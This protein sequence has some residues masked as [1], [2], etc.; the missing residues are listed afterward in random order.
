[1]SLPRVLIGIHAKDAA[2]LLPL[3]LACIEALDYPKDRICVTIK[4]NNNT[5]DTR[6]ILFDWLRRMRKVYSR[7]ALDDADVYEKVERFDRH[8]WNPERFE[9]L[10]FIR[11]ASIE[12]T[13]QWQCDF[14]FTADCDNFVR[15]NTLRALVDLNLPI[16]APF[17]KNADPTSL[18][19]NFH[20]AVDDDGYFRSSDAYLWLFNQQIRGINEVALVHCTYL[21]RADVIPLLRYQDGSPR[22]EYVIFADSARRA[23]VKQYLDNRTTYGVLT[24][25]D[26]S[27][28]AAAIMPKP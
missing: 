25:D 16:V 18:Y 11:R 2:G 4:T 15:P 24:F 9:V 10:G 3:Y 22:H 26:D 6:E 14:Y 21:V 7:V 1:M 12:R 19:S 20:E 28:R 13:E 23:G 5:D 27:A 17:L 8:E